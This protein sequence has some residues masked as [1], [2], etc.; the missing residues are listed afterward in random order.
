MTT[1]RSPL[2]TS[3][4]L[5]SD[6][7]TAPFRFLRLPQV[8]ERTGLSRSQIYRL[9]AAG[10]FPQRVKLG[11]SASAWLDVEIAQWQA[12]RISESRGVDLVATI[13]EVGSMRELAKA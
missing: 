13:A 12:D 6:A 8:R 7:L 3:A 9:E 4:A 1:K 11:E 2:R 5:H 10:R